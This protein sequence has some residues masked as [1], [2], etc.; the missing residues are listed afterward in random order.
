MQILA[1][2]KR[3]KK[4]C[5]NTECSLHQLSP[6]IGK[7]K[8]SIARE[9]VERYSEP[10][11]LVVDPFAGAGTIPFEALMRGRRTFASDSASGI[12]D[13]V[14][15][16]HIFAPGQRHDVVYRILRVFAK[17]E[18]ICRALEV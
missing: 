11:D 8:S 1:A 9:L 6:Y 2:P 7:L 13:S 4:S 3:W 5:A 18:R 17:P 16:S 14:L 12:V 10:G 15:Y